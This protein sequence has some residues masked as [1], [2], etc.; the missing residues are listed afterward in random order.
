MS[1]AEKTGSWGIHICHNRIDKN[2]T[3]HLYTCT[4]CGYKYKDYPQNLPLATC[5]NCK[6]VMREA[7]NS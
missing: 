4:Q 7:I 1:N 6:A 3:Q 5:P 2:L